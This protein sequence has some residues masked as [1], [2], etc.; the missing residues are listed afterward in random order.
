MSYAKRVLDSD[1]VRDNPKSFVNMCR[2]II[3]VMISIRDYD[4][5][6]RYCRLMAEKI[7]E[8]SDRPES[9]SDVFATLARIQWLTGD[10]EKAFEQM[11]E[12]IRLTDIR[13]EQAVKQGDPQI[14]IRSSQIRNYESLS[15]WL[16]KQDDLP[17]AVQTAL[18]MYP[19]L[20]ALEA[21]QG[22]SIP[23][24]MPARLWKQFDFDVSIRLA[25]L[26][27]R[28]N[29]KEE[30][31]RWYARI[32][33][34]PV[35]NNLKSQVSL[36]KYYTR[37]GQLRK[38]V[39]TLLPLA[40]CVYGNDS[41]NIIRL[42]AHLGL[43]EA[44]RQM[45]EPDK[46]AAVAETA[47]QLQ[48]KL[49]ERTQDSDALEF[50]T[51]QETN[52]IRNEM[53]RLQMT[54][55][56]QR[57][58]MVMLSGGAS[59]LLLLIYLTV[60]NLRKERRKNRAIVQ[61]INQFI[62]QSDALENARKRIKQLKAQLS[63]LNP[64]LVSAEDT[65]NQNEESVSVTRFGISRPDEDRKLY[66]QLKETLLKEERYLAPQLSREMLV[67]L[68]HINKNK[69]AQ[70]IQQYEGTNLNGMVNNLR[71]EYSIRLLRNQQNYT[72]QAVA[73]DSGFNNVRTYYRLFHERYGMTPMEF[74]R[75]L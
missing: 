32:A 2:N 31:A 9:K 41:V 40:D 69:L 16:A 10:K 37:S 50:A 47:L 23:Y 45:G 33:G 34:N 67:K 46:A 49:A 26:Y 12:A 17:D 19:H 13:I 64:S 3:P 60:R 22:D 65:R 75:E 6:M 59:L 35:A 73:Y 8:M 4:E 58:Y 29:N 30:E 68:T 7:E 11:Q 21:L 54:N 57:I 5:A 39:K 36:A 42:N 51:I 70:I 55:Q 25:T 28:L 44:Y 18:R 71:L 1:S 24:Q 48:S 52:E 56:L 63:I 72:I 74:R 43:F 62:E 14:D 15:L 61:Q 66:D 53:E 20:Q 27:A 38:A